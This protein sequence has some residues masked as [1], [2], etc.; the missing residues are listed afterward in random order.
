[1][2]AK[3][4]FSY[5]FIFLNFILIRR[6]VRSSKQKA[7]DQVKYWCG[8]MKANEETMESKSSPQNVLKRDYV[9]LDDDEDDEDSPV[10]KKKYFHQDS[11]DEEWDPSSH[12]S[13]AS[14]SENEESNEFCP[15]GK[16]LTRS[17]A[18]HNFMKMY[19]V[20]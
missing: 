17:N 20:K 14:M 15:K 4:F 6:P 11:E 16:I 10:L 12:K 7:M 2:F 3:L 5:I 13:N 1:M 18:F 19:F 9:T 8:T